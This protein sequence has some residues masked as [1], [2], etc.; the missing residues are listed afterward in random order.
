MESVFEDREL[1]RTALSCHLSLDLSFQVI[2]A[3]WSSED[4]GKVGNDK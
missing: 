3:A 4:F 1:A 2:H